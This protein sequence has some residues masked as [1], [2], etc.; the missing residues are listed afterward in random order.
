MS[1]LSHKFRL[2]LLHL[3]SYY[4]PRHF[5]P[6]FFLRTSLRSFILI[7]RLFIHIYIYIF[8]CVSFRFNF[9]T[10]SLSPFQT[11]IRGKETRFEV[12]LSYPVG[13][14]NVTWLR[15]C[16]SALDHRGE[17]IGLIICLVKLTLP[18]RHLYPV[19]R[20][21]HHPTRSVKPLVFNYLF[22]SYRASADDKTANAA[23]TVN[24]YPAAIV[25]HF[26]FS[27]S[28]ILLQSSLT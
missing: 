26:S 19:Q 5:N 22:V 14:L 12:A 21:V 27:I 25:R 23:R 20:P 4:Q 15:V 18:P 11:F 8:V 28:A 6:F 16:S 24:K 9:A 13:N 17:L 1:I 7:S 3:L 2:S 10:F